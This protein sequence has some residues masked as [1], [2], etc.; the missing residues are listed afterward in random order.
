MVARRPGREKRRGTVRD[1]HDR[2]ITALDLGRAGRDL[3]LKALAHGFADGTGRTGA[4]KLGELPRL[5]DHRL[6]LDVQPAHGA[7]WVEGAPNMVER[8]GQRK[9]TPLSPLPATPRS[10]AW[11]GRAPG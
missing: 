5:R 9:L 8:C 3:T 10:S 1:F 2:M 6:V 7:P 4:E 11:P